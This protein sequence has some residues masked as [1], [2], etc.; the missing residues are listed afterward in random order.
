[1]EIEHKNN[2][3]VI[4][5]QSST[6]LNALTLKHGLLIQEYLSNL[7]KTIKAL[8]MLSDVEKAFSAG[9]DL[10]EFQ[11]N[12]TEEYREQFLAA[13]TSLTAC[14]VPIIAG[15]GGYAFGGGLEVA[16]MA[17][18]LIASEQAIFAQPELTV[19]TIPGLGATQRLVKR[20]GYYRA[21]DLIFSSRRI[22]AKT[23]LDWGLVSR[24][25]GPDNLEKE[26]FVIAET[27]A[28]RSL[29][30]LKLAKNAIKN[31]EESFLSEGLLFEK[32]CF[33]KTFE[34]KDQKE[35]FSAFSDKR[36]PFFKDE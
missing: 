27:I 12:P 1:V 26:A 15:I 30:S 17:D 10:K 31:A 22:D 4:R 3:S 11:A 33:L 8:V 20:V 35:G 13:W 5:F 18:I 2:I 28:T 34:T 21:A 32:Q 25:V 23:A 24:V 9:I 7:P 29:P 16:L 19:G 6:S 36:P 14:E